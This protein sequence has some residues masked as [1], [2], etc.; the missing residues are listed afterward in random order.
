MNGWNEACK[1]ITY[2]SGFSYFVLRSSDLR[3][4]KLDNKKSEFSKIILIILFN[5][6]LFCT[7]KIL[8][9]FVI[10]KWP[11]TGKNSF[12]SDKVKFP[13]PQIFHFNCTQSQINE[14]GLNKM[15]TH[16]DNK[17]IW[18]TDGLVSLIKQQIKFQLPIWQLS[19]SVLIQHEVCAVWCQL[20]ESNAPLT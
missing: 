7:L 6:I 9:F 17:Y 13:L 20:T 8:I 11:K 4:C 3:E 12:M 18:N 1:A 19:L 5:S 10:Q 2:S 14:S 15:E 16:R